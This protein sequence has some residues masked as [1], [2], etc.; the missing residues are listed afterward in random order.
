MD[1]RIGMSLVIHSPASKCQKTK[2][3][4]INMADKVKKYIYFLNINLLLVF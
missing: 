1:N 3:N 2:H 4:W